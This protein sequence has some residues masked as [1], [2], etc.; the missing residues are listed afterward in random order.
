MSWDRNLNLLRKIIKKGK[1]FGIIGHFNPDGDS[2]GSV[3][4]MFH[5]L[6]HIG[7]SSRVI[8]PSRYPSF[9]GFLDKNSDYYIYP[10]HKS[11]ILEYISSC[12][13]IICLDFNKL[14]RV[15]DL[16]MAVSE[17]KAVKILIDHHPQPEKESF[18]IIFSTTETS[19][20]SEL[21]FWILLKMRGVRG[22][23]A[24]LPYDCLQALGT[25]MLTDTNNFNNSSLSS[26]FEMASRLLK[27]G[28]SLET[29]NRTVFGSF[30]EQRMNLMGEML[31]KNMVI[32]DNLHIGYMILSKE[33]QKEYDYKIGD[34]EGFVNLPL[35]IEGVEV[36]ALFVENDNFIRV[37]LRS[38]G[39]YSV[40]ALSNMFFNGGG[41]D[42]AAGGKLFITL[43]EVPKY[44]ED[45]FETFLKK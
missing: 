44:F 15:E 32:I 3:S 28:I 10:D 7:K 31:N 37:S 33:T 25:G 6:N 22:N 39:K 17:S 11:E 38:K 23:A 4:A 8:L 30:S 13:T 14:D 12:D 19:S 27:C 41:H 18:D 1:I 36:S 42:K 21:L 5:Y 20:T 45:S 16:K 43:D 29:I 40:N 34:S 2:V 26:T 24:K 35:L 9:L